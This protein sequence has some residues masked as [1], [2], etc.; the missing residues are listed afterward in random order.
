MSPERRRRH[1]EGVDLVLVLDSPMSAAMHTYD[2]EIAR[3]AL[4]EPAAPTPA[5]EKETE[6]TI[7]ANPETASLQQ[8]Y[9]A[10]NEAYNELAARVQR[11]AEHLGDVA[12]MALDHQV[13]VERLEARVAEL[14]P[15]PKQPDRVNEQI[16]AYLRDIVP[17]IWMP[18]AGIAVNLGLDQKS[19]AGRLERL[20]R[21]PGTAI[22]RMGGRG[23]GAHPLYRVA[24]PA[25]VVAGQRIEGE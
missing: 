16:T 24:P 14:E 7:M 19:V 13:R 23:T 15:K 25:Q 22:E 18:P 11:M 9:N 6:M 17:G 3:R 20:S 12:D 1:I 21:Q 4:E 5:T 10:L 2:Y 8:Q